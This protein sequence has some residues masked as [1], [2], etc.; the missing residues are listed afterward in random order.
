M[1][2]GVQNLEPDSLRIL[3]YFCHE[4]SRG[5][6]NLVLLLDLDRI[7]LG[8]GV[9]EIGATVRSR[10]EKWIEETLI[11]SEHR[12]KVEVKLAKLGSSAGAI[13][14]AISTTNYF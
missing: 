10:V 14:A 11:G 13:G 2:S 6:I 3:D 5:L 4:I 1:S 8:G 12:P 7:V 9:C